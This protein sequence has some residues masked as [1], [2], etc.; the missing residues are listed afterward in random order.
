LDIYGCSQTVTYCQGLVSGPISF[1]VSNASIR[2]VIKSGTGVITSVSRDYQITPA[3][4]FTLGL[5]VASSGVNQYTFN[6]DVSPSNVDDDY[7]IRAASIVSQMLTLPDNGVLYGATNAGVTN[8]HT[9]NGCPSYQ[10]FQYGSAPDGSPLYGEACADANNVY[11]GPGLN[12][13]QDSQTYS[14]SNYHTTV[15]AFTVAHELGHSVEFSNIPG[16]Q[17]GDYSD[18]TMNNEYC[19]CSYVTSS[20]PIHCLQSGHNHG[21]AFAEGWA[22]F[23]AARVMNNIGDTAPRFTYYKDLLTVYDY[24]DGRYVPISTAPPVP[25][26]AGNPYTFFHSDTGMTLNGWVQNWCSGAGRSSEYD[27]LTFLWSLN[28]INGSG[29]LGFPDLF[30]IFGNPSVDAENPLTWYTVLGAAFNAFGGVATNPKYV[31]F[32]TNGLING[33]DL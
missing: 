27:W 23:F 5:H 26:N 17:S 29:R 14:L 8:V 18:R 15:D 22:H 32:N 21:N 28:G 4:N 24:G 16:P 19:D 33:V 3:R 10:A 13:D 7:A 12:F 11:Y 30:A 6:G 20:N 1:S 2:N 31:R 25:V 9:E